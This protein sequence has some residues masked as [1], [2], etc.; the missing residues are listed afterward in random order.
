MLVEFLELRF[1]FLCVW[2][3]VQ[4]YPWRNL[5]PQ[6]GSLGVSLLP[7]NLTAFQRRHAFFLNCLGKWQP[8]SQL[9]DSFILYKQILHLKL[10]K[11]VGV[12]S[13]CFL[14]L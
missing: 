14:S 10:K 6:A 9:S 3:I 11:K 13:R 2:F 8:A 4:T 5:N 7:C 1:S 12:G